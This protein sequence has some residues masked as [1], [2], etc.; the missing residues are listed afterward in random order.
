V[1]PPPAMR[2][3]CCEADLGS[4]ARCLECDVELM[5]TT[6]EHAGWLVH[7]GGVVRGQDEETL[8][9][10]LPSGRTVALQL[11]AS[12]R[13]LPE[14]ARLEPGAQAEVLGALHRSF[15]RG[16]PRE[17]A[18][19]QTRLVARAVSLGPDARARMGAELDRLRPARPGLGE[20]EIPWPE[21]LRV[22]WRRAE[23][24]WRLI[25]RVRTRQR[26]L[27]YLFVAFLMLLYSGFT[28]Y[29]GKL[30]VAR[31]PVASVLSLLGC[32]A[33]CL[34]VVMPWL[35]RYSVISLDTRRLALQRGPTRL[36]RRTVALADAI[37][38]VYT[39]CEGANRWSIEVRDA[40]GNTRRLLALRHTSGIPA[41][42]LTARVLETALGIR[43]REPVE[44]EAQP[45]IQDRLPDLDQVL[46]RAREG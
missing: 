19:Q 10:T 39:A 40:A 13:L 17:A 9:L 30:D 3:P 5:P 42:L 29:V 11:D 26:T 35:Q 24:G 23:D 36:F 6:G 32:A 34:I 41:L 27:V 21:G 8:E 16:G 33:L 31:N 37:A 14:D 25:L 15:E 1:T 45:G 38:A 20:R 44:H 18:V 28:L 7:L 12:C 43:D 46:R 22:A 4:R 2:C